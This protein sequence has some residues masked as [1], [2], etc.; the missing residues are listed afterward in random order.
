M[1][2]S[3]CKIILRKQDNIFVIFCWILGRKTVIRVTIQ[4][5][6]DRSTAVKFSS[7]Q[8]TYHAIG[9]VLLTAEGK[10]LNCQKPTF[11]P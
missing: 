7:C 3:E 4:F 9:T 5:V 8:N 6:G 11:S 10:T 1:T 2:T